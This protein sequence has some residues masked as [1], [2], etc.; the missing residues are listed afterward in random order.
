MCNLNLL[1]DAHAESMRGG[2]GLELDLLNG[3]RVGNINVAVAGT[4]AQA[5]Q[6]DGNVANIGSGSASG[7]ATGLPANGSPVS[8]PGGSGTSGSSTSSSS[9]RPPYGRAWGYRNRFRVA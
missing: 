5:I 3:F 7:S 8:G 6:G 1:S 4:S 2:Y 9:A